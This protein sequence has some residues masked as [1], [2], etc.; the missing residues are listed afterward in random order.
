MAN[1]SDFNR[2]FGLDEDDTIIADSKTDAVLSLQRYDIAGACRGIDCQ[3]LSEPTLHVRL[4]T[5]K[6]TS[7]GTRVRNAL[8]GS[9]Y[10]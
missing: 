10:C 9:E 8:H 2:G 7:G 1:R 5:L 6:L 4:E 3:F